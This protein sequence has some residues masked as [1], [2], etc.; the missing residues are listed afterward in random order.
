MPRCSTATP[1]DLETEGHMT[2]PDDLNRRVRALFDDLL[3]ALVRNGVL[4][5]R[6]KDLFGRGPKFDDQQ[7]RNK[8]EGE[9]A[10][11]G[12]DPA[13]LPVPEEPLVRSSQSPSSKSGEH[14]RV[15]SVVAAPARGKVQNRF[16][17]FRQLA[18]TTSRRDWGTV[19]QI[20]FAAAFARELNTALRRLLGIA[21]AVAGQCWVAGIGANNRQ[22][23]DSVPEPWAANW[24]GRFR[25]ST[26]QRC[27]GAPAA[28]H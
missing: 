23:L 11:P 25:T 4:V 8:A 2:E 22:Q 7:A 16:V 6:E 1:P 10:A 9:I 17:R 19:F 21:Q 5:E 14:P 13:A 26:N 3:R 18:L 28:T 20:P 12:S 15:G 24:Q 27:F